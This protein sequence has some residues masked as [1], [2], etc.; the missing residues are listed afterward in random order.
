MKFTKASLSLLIVVVTILPIAT[1]MVVLRFIATRRAKRMPGLEDWFSLC[2]W[3]VLVVHDVAMIIGTVLPSAHPRQY[4]SRAHA[5]LCR[6]ANGQDEHYPE[7]FA[8]ELKVRTLS[9][10]LS[11]YQY[12]P[13][14]LR[15]P[16][17]YCS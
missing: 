2:A 3:A 9:A 11:P 14:Y 15:Q 7:S 16:F 17:T 5:P 6:T 8:V 1:L 4:S 12:L 10:R 13:R